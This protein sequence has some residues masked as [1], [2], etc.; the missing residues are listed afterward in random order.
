MSPGLATPAVPSTLY[1]SLPRPRDPAILLSFDSE[2]RE[3]EKLKTL[4]EK[5]LTRREREREREKL[6]TSPILSFL[7]KILA[8]RELDIDLPINVKEREREREKL[9]TSPT[10][11]LL[12]KILTRRELDIDLC[13]FV[14]L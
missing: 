2:Q 6:K 14:D 3:R 10:L 11:S 4:L 7:E 8:R 9:K 1:V 12:E 5:I 13:L